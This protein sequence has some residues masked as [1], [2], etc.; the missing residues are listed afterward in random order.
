MKNVNSLTPVACLCFIVCSCKSHTKN[1]YAKV[2]FKLLISPKAS[3]NHTAH[4][5]T[6]DIWKCCVTA[7]W[8]WGGAAWEF[9]VTANTDDIQ[10][11]SDERCLFDHCAVRNA[12]S[13]VYNLHKSVK[14]DGWCGAREAQYGWK[15]KIKWTKTAHNKHAHEG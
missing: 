2:C 8:Y 4:G 11:R 7:W 3:L 15:T 13:V 14:R 12:T 6:N 9:R 1:I 5:V 10:N